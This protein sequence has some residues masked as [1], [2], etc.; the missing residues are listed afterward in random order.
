M[1]KAHIAGAWDITWTCERKRNLKR[2]S[3][4]SDRGFS[5]VRMTLLPTRDYSLST[6]LGKPE[7]YWM[8]R[9]NGVVE[10]SAAQSLAFFD[11]IVTH[12]QLRSLWARTNS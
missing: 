8:T 11:R 10:P 5:S 3:R 12:I 6:I 7:L 9:V 1:G 4:N 2:Q